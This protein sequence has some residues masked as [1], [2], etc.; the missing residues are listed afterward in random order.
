MM[1]VHAALG[2]GNLR[3][4]AVIMGRTI[5]LKDGDAGSS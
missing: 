1:A 3:P 5:H 2:M 4:E